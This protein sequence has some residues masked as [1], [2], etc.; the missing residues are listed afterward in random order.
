[1]N[2][3]TKYDLEMNAFG[4]PITLPKGTACIFVKGASGTH[5]DLYA[6]RD[7]KVISDLTGNTHDPIYRYTWVDAEH[8]EPSE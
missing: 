5:G 4:V 8:L 1:M 7:A 2:Y 3:R 6:V